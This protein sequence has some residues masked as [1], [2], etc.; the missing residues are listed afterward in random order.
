[1][2]YLIFDLSVVIAHIYM[3]I[4][5]FM[6]DSNQFNVKCCYFG[7]YPLPLEGGLIKGECSWVGD[8]IKTSNPV[9]GA[10]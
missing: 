6:N 9:I 1:M 5:I 8:K 7:G 3:H 10:D 4:Q 2:T